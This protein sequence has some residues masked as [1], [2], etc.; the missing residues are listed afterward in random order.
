MI[1]LFYSRRVMSVLRVQGF[2][3]RTV[4]ANVMVKSTFWVIVVYTIYSLWC[5]LPPIPRFSSQVEKYAGWHR[6]STDCMVQIRDLQLPKNVLPSSRQS[7]SDYFFMEWRERDMNY[8]TRQQARSLP[9]LLIIARNR[10]EEKKTG[11]SGKFY[12]SLQT[13]ITFIFWFWHVLVSLTKS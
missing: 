8:W 13:S 5:L 2:H 9:R 1:T 11:C 6:Q 4:Y 12:S 3:A 7:I 10:A